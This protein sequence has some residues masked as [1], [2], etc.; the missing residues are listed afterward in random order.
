MHVSTNYAD[1][2]LNTSYAN[3]EMYL[4]AIGKHPERIKNLFFVYA[5]V[6]RAVNRA[7]TIL[8]SYEYQS[9]TDSDNETSLLADTL[10]NLTLTNCEVPFKEGLLFKGASDDP[11]H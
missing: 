3:H 2:R 11:L 9:D 7:E 4:E 1:F 5:A 8:R 6:L 10:L